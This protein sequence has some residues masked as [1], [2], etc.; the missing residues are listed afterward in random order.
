MGRQGDPER[1]RERDYK[2]AGS[3]SGL[4]NLYDWSFCHGPMVNKSD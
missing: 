2:I 4:K 3:H 1:K